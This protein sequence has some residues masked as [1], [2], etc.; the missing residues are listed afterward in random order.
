MKIAIV[1]YGRMGHEVEAIAKAHGHYITSIIDVDNQQDFESE[2]FRSADVAIGFSSPGSAWEN[3]QKCWD[4]GLPVVSGT[5]GWQDERIWNEIDERCRRGAT[6]LWA[7]NFSIGLNVT[8][9]ATRLL[10]RLLSP[11]PEY[12]ASVHEIH[13]IHKKDHPSG[14]AI[15]LANSIVETNERYDA[16]REETD[17]AMSDKVLP[18]THERIGEVSGIHEVKWDS[19]SDTITLKHEAKSRKGFAYGALVAAEWL[20]SAPKGRLYSMNDLLKTMI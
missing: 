8:N 3:L 4:A 19:D 5:T 1:G 12:K 18:V 16:W 2:E 11:Y 7:P 20:A 13:H 9:A 17:S 6:L 10:A 15:L 14:S